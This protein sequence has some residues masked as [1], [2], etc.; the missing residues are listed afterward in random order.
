MSAK[1]II[2]NMLVIVLGVAI[3]CLSIGYARSDVSIKTSGS[4]IIE[5]ANWDVHLENPIV[6]HNSTVLDSA[7]AKVPTVNEDG[8]EVDFIVSLAPGETYEFTID[9]VND[10]TFN[11]K[12]SNYSLTAKQNG[13]AITLDNGVESV[14]SNIKYEVTGVSENESL[15]KGTFSTK[16]VKVTALEQPET[17]E[18]IEAKT[19]E[20]KFNMY[21]IQND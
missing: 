17:E 18:A 13:S 9:V 15:N 6:T 16:R 4:P 19:Y 7:V 1:R 11:A 21:Y 8:T 20:F 10:G 14:N 3:I 12:L 2:Q 5:S